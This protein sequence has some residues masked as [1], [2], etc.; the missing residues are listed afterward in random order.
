MFDAS[1]FLDT[2]FWEEEKSKFKD[3]SVSKSEHNTNA[4]LAAHES[5]IMILFRTPQR[6]QKFLENHKNA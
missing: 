3:F 1:F 4:L 5:K 2:P 6:V